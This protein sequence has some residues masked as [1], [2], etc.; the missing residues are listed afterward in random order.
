MNPRAELRITTFVSN[1]DNAPGAT[2][3]CSC[4]HNHKL[5]LERYENASCVAACLPQ[6]SGIDDRRKGLVRFLQHLHLLRIRSR[7]RF[8]SRY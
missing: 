4:F 7:G 1:V 6:V 8:L 3:T 2:L 5:P